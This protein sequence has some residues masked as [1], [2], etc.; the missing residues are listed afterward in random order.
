[1]KKRVSMVL[2]ATATIW[3][4][5]CQKDMTN[6]ISKY[7]ASVSLSTSSLA[8]ST[9]VVTTQVS[10]SST[11]DVQS[12]SLLKLDGTDS[13]EHVRG[14]EPPR[15]HDGKFMDFGRGNMM[16]QIP[17]ISDCATVTTS[18]T[19]YPKVITVDYGTGCSDGR[20]PSKSGKII[21][22]ISD[23]IVTS[24]SLKTVTTE[25]FFI[26]SMAVEYNASITN[27]GKNGQGYWTIASAYSQ[28]VTNTNGSVALKSGTDTIE[29]INGFETATKS[30]D[31]FY[32]S[33]SGSMT[34]NDT[35]FAR[36]ITKPLLHDTCRD[37][38]SG[39]VEL[40]KNDSIVAIIDYGTGACD[41]KATVTI[42][43]TTEEIDLHSARFHEGG[44][45]DNHC[46]G[47]FKGGNHNGGK[48][49]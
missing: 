34:I 42:N 15:G 4:Q 3:F 28:K 46:H 31:I 35:T 47:G 33:G 27:L 23:T 17:R 7:P 29:W 18:S 37:I 20:G 44:R 16:F 45:F 39:T 11:S 32:E 14:P 12:V 40:L 5:G 8:A 10:T 22:N 26:D 43:G 36:I 13:T 2:M 19:T 38:T 24:G 1:M 25:N 30:D 6:S 9:D 49:H 48:H 21:I 41:N